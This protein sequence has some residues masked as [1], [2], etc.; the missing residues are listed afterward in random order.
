MFAL[1]LVKEIPLRFAG[2]LVV[3]VVTGR[4]D[5]VFSGMMVFEVFVQPGKGGGGGRG[6][7]LEEMSVRRK[8]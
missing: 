3:A 6:G 8:N 2:F 4:F 1:L 5:G 7:G